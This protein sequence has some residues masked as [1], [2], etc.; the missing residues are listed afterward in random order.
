MARVAQSELT[1]VGSTLGTLN[2]MSPEQIRGQRCTPAAD[3]FSAGIVFFQLASGRHPFS[4]RE[5]SLAQVVSA[6]VF[7]PPPKLAETAPD[8]PE[9]LEFLLN[10]AMAKEPTQR[11]QSAGELRQ[12]VS[13]CRITL[14]LAGAAP[15]Q[16][17]AATPAA[18]HAPAAPAGS[19]P[20][21]GEKTRVMH[22]PVAPP[23]IAPDQAET[24]VFR[25]EDF[26]P[27]RPQPGAPAPP[28]H[29]PAP[30]PPAQPG[31]PVA[32]PPSS[33]KLRYCPACTFA[34]QPTATFCGGCGA[35]LVI[36]G[37]DK[38][39]SIN[40]ALYTAIG[41]AVLLAI[42]LIVVLLVKK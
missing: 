25:R 41:V 42:A 32:A 40:W 26:A 24:R 1:K 15:A 9:G 17:P 2:Y 5:R 19:P 7:E 34:N 18:S 4:S 21:D 20:Q 36:P 38:P 8:A 30:A 31:T 28:P 14:D 16:Q 29:N 22:R 12:A 6:I 33:P 23:V 37:E 3:V 27:V 35:A 13:L 10:K 39:A 11:F